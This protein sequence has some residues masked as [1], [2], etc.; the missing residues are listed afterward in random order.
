MSQYPALSRTTGTSRNRG[1]TLPE[2][3]V[4]G[5]ILS[6]V[7]L[8][9]VETFITSNAALSGST[10]KIEMDQAFRTA[11]DRMTPIVTTA[12][13]VVEPVGGTF[14]DRMEIVTTEDFL[15]PGYDPIKFS[16][17]NEPVSFNPL[18]PVSYNYS[19]VFY[20]SDPNNPFN[21]G[22]IRLARR[23]DAETV[24]TNAVPGVPYQ[25]LAGVIDSTRGT[26]ICQFLVR[27]KE[28]TNAY[29]VRMRITGDVKRAGGDTERVGEDNLTDP[30]DPNAPVN[31]DDFVSVLRCPALTYN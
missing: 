26:G 29:E 18:T 1:F 22:E 23:S 6:V 9:L 2:L 31:A 20:D 5:L 19:I 7:G 17:P 11:I 16:D 30:N 27:Q 14:V 25:R 12:S 24:R 8:F 28:A 10:T 3:A 15:A 13:A 21:P 4:V